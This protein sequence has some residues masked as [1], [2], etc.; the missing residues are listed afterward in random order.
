MTNTSILPTVH[1][2]LSPHLLKHNLL[3]RCVV[4]EP[5]RDVDGVFPRE[6]GGTMTGILGNC[7]AHGQVHSFQAQIRQTVGTDMLADLVNFHL[8]RD[9]F[10]AGGHI[11]THET[12][13]LHGR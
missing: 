5:L 12:G 1:F 10:T 13:M 7:F 8:G 6:T 9:Q 11:N 2:V 3:P 4:K